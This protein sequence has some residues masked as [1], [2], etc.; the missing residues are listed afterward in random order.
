MGP[1]EDFLEAFNTWSNTKNDIQVYFFELRC[2][3]S[4]SVTAEARRDRLSS[5][6]GDRRS[7][8]KLHVNPPFCAFCFFLEIFDVDSLLVT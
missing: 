5:L 2:H 7:T 6:H 3:V 8:L 1:V 4:A